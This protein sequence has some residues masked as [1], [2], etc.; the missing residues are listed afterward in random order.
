MA[1]PELEIGR[2]DPG[3]H[4]SGLSLL[5]RMSPLQRA[6]QSDL[7]RA[8]QDPMSPRYHRWLTPEQVAA[9]LGASPADIA[10][11]SAWLRS[12]G[13]SVD[14][15]AR[16]GTRAVFSGSVAEVERAFGTELHHY[17][18][19]GAKHFAMSRAPSVPQELGGLVLGVHG[20][21]DFRARAPEHRLQPQ[22]ALSGPGADGG[23]TQFPALGPPDFAKIYDL[24]SLYAAKITGA[25][26]SIATTGRSDF[27]DADIAAFR[28]QFGLPA[29]TPARALVPNTGAAFHNVNDI[30]E[31]EVDLEWAGAVA[32]DAKLTLVFVGDAPNAEALDALNYAIEE[33]TAPIVSHSFGSCESFYT[34]TD[35]EIEEGYGA[36]AALEGMTVVVATGD[37]GAAGCDSQSALAAQ[38]GRTVWFPASVPS[39]TA[40]GGSQLQLTPA[41]QATYLDAQLDVL[42]YIPEA[43]WNET[44]EDIDAGYG[45]LGAGGG[46][47]SRLF[48]KPPWQTP[49]TPSD[50]ARDLPDVVLTASAD[51]LPYVVSLSWTA[52]DG[53]AQAPQP[54]ALTAY[55]GT[56]LAAPSFAGFVALL[57]QSIEGST[58]DAGVGLGNPNPTLYALASSAASQDAFHDITTGDNIVPCVQGSPDCPPDPPFQLGY[59]A[60]AGYDQATGLG[61]IDGA[62]LVAA[63]KALTPTS[64]TMQVHDVGS[65]AGAPLQLEA[66]VQS[67]ATANQMGGAVT[68]YFVGQA[69]GGP[70]VSGVLGVVPVVP[71]TS[72]TTET[73]AAQLTTSAPGGLNGS[74]ARIGAFYGGDVHYLASWSSF[75]SVPGTSSL[76][77]CPTTVALAVGQ[78]GFV[79]T[80]TGGSPPVQ[81]GTHAD[82]TCAKGYNDV[83]CSSIDGG[84][85]TAGPIA[86]SVM[87]V[88]ADQYGSF[89]TAQVTVTPDG[90]DGAVPPLPV[91]SC[92]LDAGPDATLDAGPE[93]SATDSGI[94]ADA[95]GDGSAG[96]GQPSPGH[97]CGC[98]VAGHGSRAPAAWIGV[99][100][101]LAAW[102]RRLEPQA[103]GNSTAFGK[104]HA[105]ASRKATS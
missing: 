28:S 105:F 39:F 11:A 102:R 93:A 66:I 55:G 46:G 81:W 22:Y 84:V 45:G 33:R 32:P 36:I 19:D 97:G 9:Q 74:G 104:R 15:Q 77:I 99:L 89:A 79:F 59:A 6:L 12:Q 103:R 38:R 35:A 75:A 78:S 83:V 14:G 43:A 101:A 91:V 44:Y 82:D 88:V 25:G 31:V 65:T 23:Q 21:H 96:S 29:S 98:E 70:G 54:E 87:V 47:A 8:T 37:T 27:N 62:N 95:A 72:G 2:M 100:L 42:S 10:R 51:T 58:R 24:D 53:D 34:P 26:Q 50:G 69:D 61:S 49:A 60:A 86:G 4:L 67:Q 64:T 92:T 63:W 16:T 57:G 18:V 90:V 17:Q 1:R 3:V 73:A 76:A 68:F 20:L 13:L 30:V 5:F 71:S 56:S 85:F 52:A 80:A 7:L 41:N 40:M 48:A 94:L